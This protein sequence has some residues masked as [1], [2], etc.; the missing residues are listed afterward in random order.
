MANIQK[1]PSGSYRIRKTYKGHTYSVT[2]PYK[3][4]KAEA[5]QLIADVIRDS[6]TP[7]T[8]TLGDCCEAYLRLKSNVLSPSTIRAYRSYIRSTPPRLLNARIT[9]LSRQTLQSHVNDIAG[10]LSPKTVR[11]QWA[12]LAVVI[13]QYTGQSFALTLPQKVKPTFFVPDDADVKAILQYIR[14]SEY[15]V[16]IYLAAL[17]LR[18][19]EILALTPEDLTPEDT[20]IINKAAVQ[21]SEQRWIIK[22][23]K[24]VESTREIPVPH[25]VAE[26]IREQGFVY[27]GYHQGITKY[28]ARVQAGLGIEH[29]TLHKLRHYFA[30]QSAAMHIPDVQTMRLGGWQSPAIMRK[31]YTHAQEKQTKEESRKME[32]HLS[33]M[34]VSNPVSNSDRQI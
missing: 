8:E 1:L 24:T 19:S 9:A 33:R 7:S 4:R 15:E 34:V 23:T 14:G 10:H 28:L 26:R 13:K 18:R 17:G 16:A 30:S 25:Y 3:P 22:T 32:K 5:D 12:F 20:V 6:P 2:V 29:F 31:V 11:N 27:R 21:D